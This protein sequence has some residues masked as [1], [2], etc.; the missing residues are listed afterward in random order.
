MS[1]YFSLSDRELR[2]VLGADPD[3]ID[4]VSEA[5]SRFERQ[6]DPI[7][8]D[9]EYFVFD[10]EVECPECEHVWAEEVDAKDYI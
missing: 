2:R 10:V 8:Q 4:A 5:A 9:D 3:N 7:S 6:V 1:R